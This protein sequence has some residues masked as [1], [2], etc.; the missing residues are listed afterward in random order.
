MLQ[1]IKTFPGGESGMTELQG[2]MAPAAVSVLPE[3]VPV[4]MP[5]LP[6]VHVISTAGEFKAL[7]DPLRSRILGLI[8]Y[9]PATAKQIADRLAMSPS[10][11]GHHLHVLE[12]AGLV[13][14]VARRSVRGTIANYYTR[15]AF[16]FEVDLPP[17]IAGTETVGLN[18][19]NQARD[20]MAEALR[21]QPDDAVRHGSFLHFKL[22][23]RRAQIYAERLQELANTFLREGPDSE[24]EIYGFYAALFLAPAA[25]Q[26]EGG[27]QALGSRAKDE[28]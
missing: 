22:S 17:E 2:S 11:V 27:G 15:T 13:Q 12:D 7:G 8:Q 9:Q 1:L 20:E 28:S 6:L 14:I 25:L 4:V 21:Q 16:F 23:A 10:S 3:E 26:V 18:L 5:E 19:I 24:G